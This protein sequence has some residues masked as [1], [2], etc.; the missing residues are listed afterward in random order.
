MKKTEKDLKW[1]GKKGINNKVLLGRNDQGNTHILFS[2]EN[3]FI[4]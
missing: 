2:W 1:G 3:H 4:A